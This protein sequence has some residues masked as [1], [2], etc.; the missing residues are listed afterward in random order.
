MPGVAMTKTLD[1]FLS[2]LQGLVDERAEEEFGP[3][4]LERWRDPGHFRSPD[5][6]DSLAA[7]D[8]TVNGIRFAVRLEH[9]TVAEAVYYT[10]RCG[11]QAACC[12]TAALLAVGRT[13][14]QAARIT[15]RDI[16]DDVGGLPEN[17]AQYASRAAAAL[18]KAVRAATN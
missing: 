4:I 16:L 2:E 13:A 17:K 9:G 14:D 7:P 1:D 12:E 18:R 8:T 11:A 10:D 6:V 3:V 5:E 15:A